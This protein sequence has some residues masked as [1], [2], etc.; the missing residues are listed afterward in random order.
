MW[1]TTSSAAVV[2][3]LNGSHPIKTWRFYWHSG[4]TDNRHQY[5][6]QVGWFDKNVDRPSDSDKRSDLCPHEKQKNSRWQKST[7]SQEHLNFD[8][9]RSTALLI[10]F[11][12]ILLMAKHTPSRERSSIRK[13][14]TREST[15]DI[16]RKLRTTWAIGILTPDPRKKKKHAPFNTQQATCV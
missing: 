16:S 10:N 7:R 4:A 1:C 5:T 9:K 3:S 12:I 13:R 2:P 14:K 11:W 8:W 15:F 6:R